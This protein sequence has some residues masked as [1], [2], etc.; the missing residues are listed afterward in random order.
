MIDT[1]WERFGDYKTD[2]EMTETVAHTVGFRPS[3]LL[4]SSSEVSYFLY[5]HSF[6]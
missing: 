2:E 1:S 4:H 3:L 6:S 5:E